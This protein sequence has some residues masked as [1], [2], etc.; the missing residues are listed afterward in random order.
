MRNASE[1]L[2]KSYPNPRNKAI[3]IRNYQDS[4]PMYQKTVKCVDLCEHCTQG[5][6]LF[7]RVGANN[8]LT[9]K[10]NICQRAAM[11]YVTAN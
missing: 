4:K 3:G 11:K 10:T 2:A 1:E 9:N 8:V 5:S 7:T 6:K